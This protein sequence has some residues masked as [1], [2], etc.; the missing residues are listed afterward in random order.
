MLKD[1]CFLAGDF[2][3]FILIYGIALYSVLYRIHPLGGSVVPKDIDDSSM[4]NGSDR[5]YSKLIK[6]I[7]I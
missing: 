7:S 1:W 2:E 4:R 5:I 3:W 6:F